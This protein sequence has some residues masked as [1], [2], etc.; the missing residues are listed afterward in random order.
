M[1]YLTI[2]H[3]R[4]LTRICSRNR[5]SNSFP[6]RRKMK[7][8]NTV[9]FIFTWQFVGM[10]SCGMVIRSATP[11]TPH[12]KVHGANIGPIWGRQDPGGPM[13]AP[14]T[15]LSGTPSRETPGTMK[16]LH[17]DR[18]VECVHSE[19]TDIAWWPVSNTHRVY[20]KIPFEYR[21]TYLKFLQD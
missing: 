12:N 11:H 4:V 3:I 18:L 21:I 5:P 1:S 9:W 14:W 2:N 20:G 8:T 13:L 7:S 16:T 17:T 6:K 15:L 10:I 19:P